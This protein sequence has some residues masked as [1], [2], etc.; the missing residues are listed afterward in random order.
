MQCGNSLFGMCIVFL[1]I[2]E[3]RSPWSSYFDC[4]LRPDRGRLMV[5]VPVCLGQRQRRDQQHAHDDA[6]ADAVKPAARMTPDAVGRLSGTH[7]HQHHE[8]EGKVH[9][10]VC[11]VIP[12]S[13]SLHDG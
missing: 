7:Q 1:G 5:P 12:T 3:S 4:T 8:H 10:G 2:I 11:R 6:A 13:V 9:Y